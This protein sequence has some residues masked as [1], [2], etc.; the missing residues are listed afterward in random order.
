MLKNLTDALQT[1]LAT[2]PLVP[3]IALPPMAEDA[4]ALTP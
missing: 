2:A 4:S 3:S 1:G